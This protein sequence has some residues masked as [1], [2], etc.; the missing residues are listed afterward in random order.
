MTTDMPPPQLLNMDGDISSA[1]M[2]SKYLSNSANATEA[3]LAAVGWLGSVGVQLAR[4]ALRQLQR[5]T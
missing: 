5:I 1:P 3:S 4:F 2:G